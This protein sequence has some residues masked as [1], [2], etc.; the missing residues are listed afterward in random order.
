[1]GKARQM[2]QLPT[3][4]YPSRAGT[5]EYLLKADAKMCVCVC[6]STSVTKSFECRG[7]AA[8]FST[9]ANEARE[10]GG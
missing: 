1:M 7:L 9:L 2:R 8:H 3:I 10:M 4:L 5:N 6:V